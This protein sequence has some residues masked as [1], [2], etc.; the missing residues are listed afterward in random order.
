MGACVVDMAVCGGEF[1]ELQDDIT[2]RKFLHIHKSCSLVTIER[3]SGH[4][5]AD[6]E[7][8]SQKGFQHS[9]WQFN[10]E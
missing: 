1:I 7:W 6:E 5:A 10:T 4:S 9:G 8:Y 3:L 2:T